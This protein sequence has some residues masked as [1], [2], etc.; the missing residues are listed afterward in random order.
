MTPEELRD[1]GTELY[2]EVGWKVALAKDLGIN[3][4]TI[5]RWS[6]GKFEISPPTALAIRCLLIRHRYPD[7]PVWDESSDLWWKSFQYHKD[8]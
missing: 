5:K 7:S 1:I 2:G 3:V 8:A 6:A 4:S